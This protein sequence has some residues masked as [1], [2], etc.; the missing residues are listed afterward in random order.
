MIG[1]VRCIIIRCAG[2]G[3]PWGIFTSAVAFYIAVTTTFTAAFAVRTLSVITGRAT[4]A[5]GSGSTGATAAFTSTWILGA[6]VR[7]IVTADVHHFD[8]A[9]FILQFVA[10]VFLHL[11]CAKRAD[12][13]MCTS[14]AIISFKS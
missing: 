1:F 13:P 7:V 5:F 8:L 14:L 6:F 2:Y 10:H 9:V 11:L 3:T 4:T 12:Y